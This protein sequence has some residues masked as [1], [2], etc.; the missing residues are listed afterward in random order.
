MATSLFPLEQ[1]LSCPV[2]FEI[3]NDPVILS[4]SHSFCRTC[5][6]QSWEEKIE[7]ECP[8]CRCRSSED[9]LP[10]NLALRSAC[11]SFLQQKREREL[12]P[13]RCSL[14]SER[15]HLFCEKDEKLVCA[16]CV[17]QEH[18]NH[19]FCSI[20]KAAIP[21][22]G[23]LK[24]HLTRLETKL[25]I[26]Q[27]IKDISEQ[28][29]A[30]I[31]SQAQNTETQIQ[32][33]FEKLHQFL[34]EEEEAT[35]AALKE[36]EEEKSQR[37]KKKIEELDK[38][39]ME[40]SSRVT[41]L[42]NILKNDAL[43]VQDFKKASERAQYTVPDP[44]LESG[45]LI[46]VAKHLGNLSHRVWKEMK[47]LCPYFPVVLDPNTASPYLSISADFSSFSNSAEK[48]QLP[49]NPERMSAYRSVLGSE[50]FSSGTHSWAVEVGNSEDWIVGVAEESVSRKK[51][52]GAVPENGFCCIWRD[53]NNIRAGLSVSTSETLMTKPT[54]KR[55]CVT[56]KCQEG[57][58]TFSNPDN[59]TTLHTFA[60]KFTKK[61]Y[62]Y[63]NNG[64]MNSLK[65][66]SQSN[67]D[68]KSLT[69]NTSYSFISRYFFGTST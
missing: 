64:S 59:D 9:H 14:H 56:L 13:L 43:I 45:A 65:V 22:K 41:E 47:Y 11:E 7:R 1:D 38:Q 37:M 53:G 55:I 34:R 2:C 23:K 24:T 40:I 49:D 61:V 25:T 17:S 27:K 12:D 35:I 39:I 62:P 20:T 63:F 28:E 5:L 66:L 29:A 48:Y 32:E 19:S 31:K 4:C 44:Q 26:F 52:C 60:H 8:V 46:D 67:N 6:Q 30:H 36:E 21:R 54:I 3:F 18:Q 50:G 15:L 68:N 69:Q 58:V 51:T 10:T 33:E 57:L 16:K 42:N